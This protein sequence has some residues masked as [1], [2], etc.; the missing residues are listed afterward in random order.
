MSEY[1]QKQFPA[2]WQISIVLRRVFALQCAKHQVWYF[3]SGY[4]LQHSELAQLCVRLKF[5][6][7]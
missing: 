2:C 1:L 5:G 4:L 3:L 7:F 6:K